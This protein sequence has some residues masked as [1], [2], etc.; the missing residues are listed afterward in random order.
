MGILG[1]AT[2]GASGFGPSKVRGRLPFK[3]W[4]E[5]G[6]EWLEEAVDAIGLELDWR[7]WKFF[8]SAAR[9]NLLDPTYTP[10]L[11]D[12]AD[13]YIANAT[14]APS[15]APV[16]DTMLD[17]LLY[18]TLG[19]YPADTNISVAQKQALVQIGWNALRGKG[20]RIRLL[21]LA[22]ALA[23]GVAV[24]WTSPPFN[25]SVI[26]PDGAPSPGYGSWVQ[27]SSATPEVSRPWIL[28]AIRS[29]LA[30]VTPGFVNFGVGYSQFR[31]GYSSWGET[32]FPAG[33]RI[34]ILAHEHFD[35]WSVGV[36]VGW[37]K[38]G[39]GTLT[40]STSDTSINWEFT[41]NAAVFDLTGAGAGTISGLSQT[42]ANINN[43]LTHRLQFDYKYTN[44]QSVA[45]M[46][47]QI[48]DANAD[49]NIY[50]WNPT[51][52]TWSTTAYKIA[53]PIST[54]RGRY[55][56]DIVPQSASNTAITRG[57]S[58]LTVSIQ[59]MSDG[60]ATTQGAY[61]VY[62]GGLY[63]KFNLAAEQAALGER[64]ATYPL[65]DAPGWTLPS[66]AA[67]GTLLEM[68]SAT[69]ASYK[70]VGATSLAFG[71]HP[72][73]TGRGMLCHSAWTN[74][75]KGSNDFG[76]DWSVVNA[77]KASNAVISPLVGEVSPTAPSLTTTTTNPTLQQGF[78][79]TPSNKSYVG[80]IWV[81]KPSSDSSFTSVTVTLAATDIFAK[82]FT[83]KQ[84]DGWTLL[85]INVSFGAQVNTM[86]LKVT[87][88]NG[89]A[90]QVIAV[91]DAYLY[92]VTGFAGVLY[93]PVVRSA[94]GATATLAT[95][96]CKAVTATTDSNVLHPLLQRTLSSVVRGEV[97]VTVVPTFDAGSQPTT[98]GV[99]FDL[100]QGA[101]QNR[102]DLR[103]FSGQ[104]QLA[105]WDNAGNTWT[106]ALTLTK[107]PNPSA[108]QVTWLRDQPITIR[109]I[110]DE[111]S[112]MLSAGNAN[113]IGTKPGSW[114]T[115]DASVAFLRIGCNSSGVSSFD[116]TVR[117]LDAIQLGAPAV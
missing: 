108:G 53:V 58:S 77:T 78:A 54:N 19:I 36:P 42:A 52:A 55:A 72:A 89:S 71:Y 69:R 98:F 91:A 68:A 81:K 107:S 99:I 85:P 115:S 8:R 3:G 22:A 1:W 114:S 57:T 83:V 70:T 34:N 32:L 17:V 46:T 16:Q 66:R 31:W 93:P 30:P 56:C 62:R 43:Q 65:I 61:T 27:S 35:S 11:Q 45:V 106:A 33:A 9:V 6:Q 101:T 10:T 116:G 96:V 25:F 92:D 15:S 60:T 88:G 110:W 63:E 44:A 80:G 67:G 49:G 23:D 20:N 84:S 59:A 74:L 14:T 7:D 117:L 28:S 13:A 113:A 104:L 21:Q 24:G 51:T 64:T 75:V 41:G 18:I 26:I 86:V 112:T 100:N 40:Q 102:V 4:K 38:V 39:A 82:T 76:T 95:S 12:P 97:A 111:N 73:L 47:I 94:V 50:Y 29:I 48:T 103:L 2:G 109:A 105:R 90:G 79:I 87:W 5:A 37:T